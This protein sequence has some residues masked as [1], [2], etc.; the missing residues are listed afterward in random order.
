MAS[1]EEEN[2]FSREKKF[3][4]SPEPPTLFKKSEI[5][6]VLYHCIYPYREHSL[7]GKR[8]V[9]SPGYD[10]PLSE[11]E[12]SFSGRKTQKNRRFAQYLNRRLMS[13]ST[14]FCRRIC[15]KRITSR[16]ASAP[17]RI[18]IRRSMP[19]PIPPAG[20]IPYSRAVR[21]SSSTLLESSSPSSLFCS[22]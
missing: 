14:Y 15:G 7:S 5:F 8:C 20:G 19:T 10:R 16:I 2:F 11:T 3:S 13:P 6:S 21:K 17:V 22:N 1:G 12:C 18:I 4:S 9:S